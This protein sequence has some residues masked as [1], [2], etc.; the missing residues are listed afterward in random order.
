MRL[1]ARLSSRAGGGFPAVTA[2]R[3]GTTFTGP[4]WPPPPQRSPLRRGC[5]M[6]AAQYLA[7][8]Q[9]M[10]CIAALE[11][12]INASKDDLL[13][14]EVTLPLAPGHDVSGLRWALMR[15]PHAAGR[16]PLLVDV[17]RLRAS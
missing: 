12:S 1:L 9:S 10:Q 5:E 11:A 17:S 8:L 7:G 15:R 16:Q 3:I 14:N 6:D 2:G 4:R 13:A